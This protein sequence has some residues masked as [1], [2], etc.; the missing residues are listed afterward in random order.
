MN[1]QG[2]D[3]NAGP[4]PAPGPPRV[5][6][7][8]DLLNMMGMMA[9]QN[10]QLQQAQTAMQRNMELFQQQQKQLGADPNRGRREQVE[11][12][13]KLNTTTFYIIS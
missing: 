11:P 3:L 8:E 6:T 13:P 1:N 9:H 7:P 10:Q 5:I 12:L 2:A 4:G